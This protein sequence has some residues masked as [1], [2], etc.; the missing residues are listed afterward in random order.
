MRTV[1]CFRLL[2][3]TR[4]RRRCDKSASTVLLFS[5]KRRHRFRSQRRFL[6]VRRRRCA[7]CSLDADIM[8]II[9]A[10]HRQRTLDNRLMSDAAA[11]T[12]ALMSWVFFVF[13][14]I[15]PYIAPLRWLSSARVIW[16]DV[17]GASAIS[18]PGCG[19]SGPRCAVGR[20]GSSMIQ[21][22]RPDRRPGGDR[23]RDSLN[24]TILAFR[25]RKRGWPQHNIFS[26]CDL[27]IKWNTYS[28][29]PVINSITGPR[30]LFISCF[31]S[32]LSGLA[33]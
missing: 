4:P 30:I 9:P 6:R 17:R 3:R 18:R 26:R 19:R 11:A 27:Y 23:R 31:C 10:S 22:R 13:F 32:L 5:R 8:Y 28:L 21:S 2:C 16:K 29:Q 33:C 24:W 25:Q 7:Y 20:Q 14:H 15:C 1:E 12:P